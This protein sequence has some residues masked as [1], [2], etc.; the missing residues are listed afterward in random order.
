MLW[1][2]NAASVTLRLLIRKENEIFVEVGYGSST[3]EAEQDAANRIIR[4]AD[5]WSWIETKYSETSCD[6]YLEG[7][8]EL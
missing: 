4:S 7:G 5:L 6:Q 3:K 1:R 2:Q 8:Q